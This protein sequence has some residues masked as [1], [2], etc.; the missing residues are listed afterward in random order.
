MSDHPGAGTKARRK[1]RPSSVRVGMLCRF[2]CSELSL[3]VRATVWRKRAWIRPSSSDLRGKAV[4]VGAPELVDLAVSQQQVDHRVL[5]A[6][7]LEGR[8]VGRVPGLGLA[9]LRETELLVQHGLELLGGVDLEVVANRRS[10]RVL[11]RRRLCAQVL[12]DPTQHVGV[13]ADAPVLHA[14]QHPEQG[15]LHLPV[16]GAELG[17][18]ELGRQCLDELRDRGRVLAEQGVVHALVVEQ[19]GR[20]RGVS[21][22]G[23]RS[24]GDVRVHLCELVA[25]AA[26]VKQVRGDRRVVLGDAEVDAARQRGAP[27]LLEIMSGRSRASGEGPQDSVDV[28]RRAL[29]RT[30]DSALGVRDQQAA[31]RLAGERGVHDEGALLLDGARDER[32]HAVRRCERVRDRGGIASGVGSGALSTTAVGAVGPRSE[33]PC[34]EELLDPR[35]LALHVDGLEARARPVALPPADSQLVRV[36]VEVHVA[37]QP[38]H[39]GVAASELLVGCQVLAELGSQPT[40]VAEQLVEVTELGKQFR[41][42]L[43]PHPRDAGEVVR[44]VSTQRREQRVAGGLDAGALHDP[45]LVVERVVRHAPAV[46][47]HAHEGVLHELEAVSVARHDDHVAPL[48]ACPRRERREHVVRL[49]A[50][51][52][53][54]GD[55]QRSEEIDDDPELR[56]EL[57]GVASLPPL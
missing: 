6:Q 32:R 45:R 35:P 30:G 41:C 56:L 23:R 7:P 40:Q 20:C 8:S 28:A 49:E 9:A 5:T 43:L 53:D 17:I 46:V 51:L 15:Q 42:S 25:A 37:D 31:D 10:D 27:E 13:D 11:E 36:D 18:L 52:R 34:V 16:Q 22:P 57:G 50:D 47:Q 26:R 39:A 55:R 21:R 44:G 54:N 12:R 3:P 4:A 14:R 19:G 29:D 2:G 33:E 38:H 48:V 1:R 24:P